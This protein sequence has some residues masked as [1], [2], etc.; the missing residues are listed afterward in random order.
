MEERDM[1]GKRE[2]ANM[3]AQRPWAYLTFLR[4][5]LG[6]LELELRCVPNRIL[7]LETPQ[8]SYSMVE[9]VEQSWKNWS[10]AVPNRPSVVI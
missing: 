2:E 5:F 7:S 6:F 4:E 8:C 10:R 1:K 3:W 9:W